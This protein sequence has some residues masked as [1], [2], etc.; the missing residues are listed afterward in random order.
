MAASPMLLTFCL[1]RS[2]HVV[3][4]RTACDLSAA[5]LV[6]VRG[7]EEAWLHPRT[8]RRLLPTFKLAR[9]LHR[10]SIL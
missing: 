1:G 5:S 10:S 3:S 2:F 8:P 7:A 4:R 9:L 6:A